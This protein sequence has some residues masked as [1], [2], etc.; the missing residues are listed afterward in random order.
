ML[1]FGNENTLVPRAR[2]QL[3]LAHFYVMAGRRLVP[4]LLATAHIPEI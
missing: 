2:I 4:R 3:R 1:A